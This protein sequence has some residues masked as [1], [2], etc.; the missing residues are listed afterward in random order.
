MPDVISLGEALIDFVST[1]SGVRVKDAPSFEKAPGGAPANVAVG[2]AKL[3]VRTGFIGKVGGDEFG[4]CL[5]ETLEHWDVETR[6]M[7]VDDK[8]RTT[9]AFVSLTA[10][11]EPSFAFYRNPGADM[12]LTPEE[13]DLDW[14][15]SVRVFHFGSISLL[16]AP[17]REATRTAIETA[18]EAGALISYDP[19]LRPALWKDKQEGLSLAREGLEKADIVKMSEEELEEILCVSDP[20][21]GGQRLVDSG[22]LAVFITQGAAGCA[23]CC[24][25]GFVEA[26]ALRIE[27][28]DTTGAGDGFVA[29]V[30]R[31]IVIALAQGM[32]LR[33]LP[34]EWWADTARFANTVAGLSIRSK[35]AIPALPTLEEV[36][37]TLT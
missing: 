33:E 24:S 11:G 5:K 21:Q 31:Q 23:V 10:E 4:L 8:Q 6:G 32:N 14:L 20:R 22:K 34:V 26:K 29:G 25:Q 2:L 15:R 35:G 7:I 30:L 27:P 19:N 37:R 36:L 17:A 18:R 3:G 28:V 13:L 9:L 12:M 1:V 16:D